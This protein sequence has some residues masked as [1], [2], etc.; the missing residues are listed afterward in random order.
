MVLRPAV[1]ALVVALLLGGCAAPVA[2]LPDGISVSVRQTRFDGPL[3]QVQLVVANASGQPFE[4]TSAE[5]RST[6]FE[7]AVSFDRP[8][9][10]PDGSFRDLPVKLPDAT[11]AEGPPTDEIALEF[12]TAD[13]RSAFAV[14]PIAAVAILEAIATED[15]VIAAV[16]EVVSI[17]PPE[18]AQWM[19]GAHAP[20]TLDFTAL[21]TGSAGRVTVISVGATTLFAPVDARGERIVA[22][23]VGLTFDAESTATGIPIRLEPSRCDPHAIAEDKRGTLLP[24]AIEVGSAT[25][26]IEIAVD[27]AV[28]ASLYDYVADWCAMA[29]QTP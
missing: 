17:T 21:P 29:D 2:A 8:Q 9:T 25:G 14:L 20:V 23:P 16:A 15:C 19:P 11:C 13:G 5:L 27:A 22:T 12:V 7:E 1:T 3:R 6:R 18:T 10:V 24:F 28:R 4:V 26:T